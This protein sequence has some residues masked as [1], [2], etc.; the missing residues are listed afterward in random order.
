MVG[1]E[2]SCIPEEQFRHLDKPNLKRYSRRYR[3]E[4]AIVQ[5]TQCPKPSSSGEL[6]LTL[7]SLED[8]SRP[9]A[10]RKGVRTCTKHSISNFVFYDVLSPSYKA[11][12]LSIFSV[13]IPQD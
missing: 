8:L 11:L 10:Q 2:K 6:S 4:E 3:I 12:V 5:S 13:S 1:K 9:V 7:A